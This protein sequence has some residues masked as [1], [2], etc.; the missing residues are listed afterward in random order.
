MANTETQIISVLDPESITAVQRIMNDMF[1]NAR[2]DEYYNT[3]RDLQSAVK[4]H[5]HELETQYPLI[6][7][8]YQML[9]NGAQ[10]RVFDRLTIHDI[11]TLFFQ[12]IDGMKEL[13]LEQVLEAIR[14]A[15]MLEPVREDRDV[16]KQ[17][18]RDA[19]TR[20]ESRIGDTK[21]QLV[22]TLV[23]PTVKNWI[24]DWKV[25]LGDRQPTSLLLIEYCSSSPNILQLPK[26][27]VQ[28]VQKI[29]KLYVELLKSSTTPEGAEELFP[30]ANI[31][32]GTYQ[33]FDKGHL[34]DSG[35][36]MRPEEV[37]RMR[38]ERG[39][40]A[41]GNPMP[42]SELLHKTEAFQSYAQQVIATADRSHTTSVA[43]ARPT[44]LAQKK[45]V[46]N[47]EIVK[48]AP[49]ASPV[50]T[51]PKGFPT[52]PPLPPVKKAV[53]VVSAPK[54]VSA[55]A[56]TPAPRPASPMPEIQ[57]PPSGLSAKELA[58][59][60]LHET[61]LL[62]PSSEVEQRFLSVFT[63]YF[64]KKINEK[65][66]IEDLVKVPEI[67]G[68]GV[69]Q[70]EAQRLIVVAQRL[71]ESEFSIPEV[72]APMPKPKVHAPSLASLQKAMVG[73]HGTHHPKAPAPAVPVVEDI[74]GNMDSIPSSGTGNWN[75]VAVDMRGTNGTGVSRGPLAVQGAAN[76]TLMGPLDELHSMTLVEFRRLSPDPHV[77]TRY[78]ANQ[79]N[80]LEEESMA[81]KAAGIDAWGQ[82]PL[83]QQYL[84]IGRESLDRML[85]IDDV[86]R[87]Q[88]ERKEV[89]L[90]VAEF[91]A[92]SDLNRTLRF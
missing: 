10:W 52:L 15:L 5:R 11:E 78:I 72:K 85:S 65:Q 38:A 91:Q 79:L 16:L 48:D 45:I 87:A 53:P 75:P 76:P 32:T 25:F 57:K 40:D 66:C 1:A 9:I 31:D 56:R 74:F 21:I 20:S 19:L 69:T 64:A 62:L 67:G 29:F 84:R 30:V 70:A 71:N 89:T 82:S 92:I 17:K 41:S 4:K 33:L 44:M 83:N 26:E 18:L 22:D 88:N 27:T 55:P 54:P 14:Y 68:V 73:E 77:A 90:S 60:I 8:R 80:V 39:L 23:E 2:Y 12:S 7:Q 81:Q 61:G 24:K 51:A 46:R 35:L 58:Q 47:E 49:L 13:S 63:N 3:L 43:P 36:K 86:I 59:Y 34:I 28:E 50:T 42:I 6:L 37:V